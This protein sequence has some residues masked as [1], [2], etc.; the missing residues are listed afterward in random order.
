MAVKPRPSTGVVIRPSWLDKHFTVDENFNL[1]RER[2]G[3][4]YSQ[5]FTR[6]WV[7]GYNVQLSAQ[8]IIF[9][10]TFRFDPRPNRINRHGSSDPKLWDA[11][12]R[13]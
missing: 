6:V 5:A 12:G 8:T 10:M 13:E 3:K 1:V 9:M 2:N 7:P 4:V 11:D